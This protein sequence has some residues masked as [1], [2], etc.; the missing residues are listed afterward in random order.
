[1]SQRHQIMPPNPTV[2]D[3]LEDVDI[4]SY[5]HPESAFNFEGWVEEQTVLLSLQP[6]S[7]APAIVAPSTDSNPD[8]VIGSTSIQFRPPGARNKGKTPASRVVTP[9]AQASTH[10]S[11]QLQ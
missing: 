7:P 2:E 1:M 5:Y 6:H 9:A 8:E 4:V 3:T 11:N 10:M